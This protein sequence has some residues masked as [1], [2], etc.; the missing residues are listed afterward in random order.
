MIDSGYLR[1]SVTGRCNFRCGYCSPGGLLKPAADP[2][3]ETLS[4]IAR[5]AADVGIGKIRITG[6]E[7]LIRGDIDEI[8]ADLRSIPDLD[9]GITTNGFYLDRY[10]DHFKRIGLK[11][12]NVSLDSLK[13]NRFGRITGIDGLAKVM[14]ALEA[15]SGDGFFTVKVNAV[16]LRDFNV[17]ELEDFAELGGKLDAEVRF[18]EYMP[19]K[20][21]PSEHRSRFVSEAEM[22]NRLPALRPLDADPSAGARLYEIKDTG[23]RIGFISP[24]SRPFCGRCSRLRVTSSLILKPCLAFDESIDLKPLLDGNGKRTALTGA[25]ERAYRMK[26]RNHRLSAI[27]LKDTGMAEIGG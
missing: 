25:F 10:I 14:D 26:R 17:D 1:L 9:I 27:S 6:G 21:S 24:I 4:L 16:I 18:I 5:A 13:E 3:G 15:V 20:V 22:K 2:E 7:P 23:A 19:F 8:T 11:K 12:V